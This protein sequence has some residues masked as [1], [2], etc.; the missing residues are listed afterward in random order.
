M[1][2]KHWASLAFTA[3]VGAAFVALQEAVG[4]GQPLAVKV[5]EMAAVAGLAAVLPLL[6]KSP[7]GA[8]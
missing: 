4:S 3:F 8:S 5:V 2:W 6:Q 1:T 7:W